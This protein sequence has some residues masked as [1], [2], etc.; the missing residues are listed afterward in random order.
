MLKG[1]CFVTAALIPALCLALAVPPLLVAIGTDGHV[2]LRA[3]VL[4]NSRGRDLG[5]SLTTSSCNGYNTF[6]T[7][8][9]VYQAPCVTCTKGSYVYI[10][11]G[12]TG[13]YTY[14]GMNTSCGD[15]DSGE[16]SMT[17][18]CLTSGS[19]VGSCAA[20]TIQVQQ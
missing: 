20:P 8:C 17:L 7:P 19:S 13:G 12:G 16:C 6:I 4:A 3:D 10:T 18:T 5:S 9:T 14:R 11:V 2:R 1:T 15:L